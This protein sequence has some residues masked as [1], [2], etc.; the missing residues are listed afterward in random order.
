MDYVI[1]PFQLLVYLKAYPVQSSSMSTPSTGPFGLERSSSASSTAGPFAYQTRLLERTSSRTGQPRT[2]SLIRDNSLSSNSTGSTSA[3]IPKPTAIRKWAPSHRVGNS[4]DSVRGKWE[5][6]VRAENEEMPPPP[7]K[8]P[9]KASSALPEISENRSRSKETEDSQPQLRRTPAVLK[10][11]TLPVHITT[12]PLSPNNT[13]MTIEGDDYVSSPPTPLTT[14]TPQRIR[15]PT[16]LSFQSATF[17]KQTDSHTTPTTT[18]SSQPRPIRSSTTDVPT[19][20]WSDTSKLADPSPLS[21]NASS[22]FK[23]L[24]PISSSSAPISGHFEQDSS[25]QPYTSPLTPSPTKSSPASSVMSP[26]PYRSSYMAKKAKK[27]P[28]YGNDLSIGRKLGRHLPRI[29]SGDADDDWAEER[30]EDIDRRRRREVREKERERRTRALEEH[31][32][33][34]VSTAPI[35]TS[36]RK[37]L[38]SLAIASTNTGTGVTD[39]D[40]VAGIPGRLRLSKDHA[41]N[42]PDSPLP[43]ARLGGLWADTQRQHLQAYEYLCHVGEAQQWIEGCLGEELGFGVVEMEEGLRNGVVLAKLVRAFQGEKAV[44][45]IYEVCLTYIEPKWWSDQEGWFR[46]RNWT[47]VIRTT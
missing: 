42:I 35:P 24:P 41:P 22:R 25:S 9:T 7:P 19:S 27:T 21:S 30:K 32:E 23:Y 37:P 14:L 2:N 3:I 47:S 5:E 28:S 34:P 17:P 26:T 12:S 39:A 16:S 43:S 31:K 18:P 44:R 11:H 4:V 29:A 45:R 10:R 15:L 38:G 13:G 33:N 40:D 1:E 46:H 36:P 6:R 8:S 20:S